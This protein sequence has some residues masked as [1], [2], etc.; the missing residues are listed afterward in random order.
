MVILIDL[1]RHNVVGPGL[2]GRILDLGEQNWFGDVAPTEI[3]QLID[4]FAPNA[5]ADLKGELDAM[6]ARPNETQLTFD[7][8]R[9][10]YR[11]LLGCEYYRA[12]DL[13]GTE[14]AIKADLNKP[15]PLDEQ[16]DLVTNLGTSEHVFNQH[17]FFE[18]VHDRTRPG[19][20]IYHSLP[21]QGAY[22][23]G[24]FNYQPTF[25]FDLAGANG[26]EL[27]LLVYTDGTRPPGQQ[28]MQI[29]DRADYVRLAT[30]GRI[31]SQGGLHAI[32]R[33]GSDE[34]PFRAPF[35]AYYA[36]TLPPS[37]ASAWNALPK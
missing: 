6:L 16:F 24:F 11:V 7:V 28:H 18:T 9:F 36:N 5:A 26:Y 23:H 35:Q 21:H 1:R 30:E 37:L 17:Q 8:A 10:F 32:L 34:R 14:V 19:G 2:T 22:D 33:K 12:I 20:I 13:S 3:H 27:L 4:M 29:K 25:F 31:S 15:V